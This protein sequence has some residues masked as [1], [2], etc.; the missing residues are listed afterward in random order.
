MLQNPA[1]AV[2]DLNFDGAVD[3]TDLVQFIEAY[4]EEAPPADLDMNNAVDLDDLDTFLNAV[5]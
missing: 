4:I 2:A 3:A 1:F 5:G